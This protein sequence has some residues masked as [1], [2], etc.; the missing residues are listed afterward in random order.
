MVPGLREKNMLSEKNQ[1]K[2]KKKKK[3]MEE[4]NFEG[5]LK[6]R[7]GEWQ[8]CSLSWLPTLLLFL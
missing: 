5:R 3:S 1:P 8:P 7:I 4:G 2:A 6:E